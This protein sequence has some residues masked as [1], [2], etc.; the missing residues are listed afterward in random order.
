MVRKIASS[1]GV[2]TPPGHSAQPDGQPAPWGEGHLAGP[3]PTSTP[4][5]TQD[6]T[7]ISNA[8]RHEASTLNRDFAANTP[9]TMKVDSLPSRRFKIDSTSYIKEHCCSVFAK[10]GRMEEY[11]TFEDYSAVFVLLLFIAVWFLC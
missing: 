7:N 11:H 9:T 10:E 5:P 1:S 8:D 3:A 6:E 2:S 4:P